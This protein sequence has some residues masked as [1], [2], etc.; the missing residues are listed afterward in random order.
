ML[1]AMG[2]YVRRAIRPNALEDIG[3]MLAIHTPHVLPVE[4]GQ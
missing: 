2:S 3:G 4:H 1:P